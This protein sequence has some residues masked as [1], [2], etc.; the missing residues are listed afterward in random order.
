L[1]KENEEILRLRHEEK[2]SFKK[3]GERV[4]LS[5]SGVWRRHK[6]LLPYLR[7]GLKR[8]RFL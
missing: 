5:K 4:G 6:K 3:I 1:S 7:E 2:L 8:E